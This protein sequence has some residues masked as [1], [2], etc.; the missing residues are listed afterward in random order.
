MIIGM[1]PLVKMG[2]LSFD[3]DASQA[4]I[5]VL[6]QENSEDHPLILDT[7][8]IE[9]DWLSQE[10][11]IATISVKSLYNV[12]SGFARGKTHA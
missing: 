2:S 5:N 11:T 9:R 3:H 1:S 8:R 7:S 4:V 12:S 6:V 10:F